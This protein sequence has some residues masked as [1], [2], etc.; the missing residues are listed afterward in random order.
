MPT[1]RT[2]QRSFS[3]GE[4]TPELFGRV[5]WPRFQNGL[6]TCRNFIVLPH[7]PAV[8]RPGLKYILPAKHADKKSRLLPFSFSLSQTY[9]LEFGDQY[10]RFF[11]GGDSLLEATKTITGATTANPCVITSAAHGYSNGDWVYITGIVGMTRLNGR[12]FKVANKTANTFELTDLFGA[13]ID[14]S[15]FGTYSSGGTAGKVYEISSPYLEAD[16]MDIQFAQ[17]ADVLTL[18]HPSYAPRELRR[19]AAVNWTLTTI[20]LNANIAAPTGVSATAAPA[21]GATVYTYVVTAIATENLEES[22]VSSEANATNNLTVSGN[23]N[24]VNWSAVTGAVR[25]NIYRKINGLY[26]YIGQAAGTSFVDDNIAPLASSTPP[27]TVSLFSA[28]GDYPGAVCYFEQRRCFA[29][30]DNEPQNLWMSRS[31]TEANFTRS[32]PTGDDDAITVRVVA[33]ELNIIHH[34]VPLSDLIILTSGGEWRAFADGGGGITPRTLSV[35]PQGYFGASSVRPAVTGGS[36]LYAQ[37]QGAHVRELTFGTDAGGYKELK[38]VDVSIVAPHLFDDY[39]LIDM[40]FARAPNQML[41][42]VRS[43]G[44]LLSLTYVPDQEILAWQQHITDGIV[45]AVSTVAENGFDALYVVVRRTIDGSDRRYIERLQPRSFDA[46]ADAFFVDCGLTYDG[47]EA[48]VFYNLEHLEGESVVT[49]G[50]GAV[51]PAQTVTNGMITLAQGVSKAHIGLPYTSELRTLPLVVN[52][53]QSFAH[54]NLKN[55][56]RAWL[57]VYRSSGV[58]VGPS[59]DNLTEYKQRRSEPYGSPPSLLTDVIGINVNPAWN[60]SGQLTIRQT[61]PL[62]LDVLSLTVEANIGG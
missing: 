4:I 47:A 50:D 37:G 25:Y 46:L 45:E 31:A 13:A 18:V 62:P 60:I 40:A 35:K 36:I 55:I 11:T 22:L 49:L 38:T 7:G 58:F 44:V 52:G 1:I 53:K 3:G 33:R 10:I 12:F 41:W 23:K 30:S 59:A 6:E 42:C 21:S 26:G 54:G 61:A 39:T 19:V 48:T 17:S 2:L 24:T 8:N 51:F 34:L 29:G 43:D 16:L 15:A 9:I 27:E 20:T 32:I 28:T 56:N 57:R 5:D 14:S